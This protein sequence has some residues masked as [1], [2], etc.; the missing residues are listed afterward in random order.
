MLK[1]ETLHLGIPSLDSLAI[2]QHLLMAVRR[3]GK[4]RAVVSQELCAHDP[5]ALGL[6]RGTGWPHWQ[7]G[8][9]IALERA[10]DQISSLHT[11]E[12]IFFLWSE[13]V[14]FVLAVNGNC[15][16]LGFPDDNRCSLCGSVNVQRDF[17]I[18]LTCNVSQSAIAGVL[19][20]YTTVWQGR[21]HEN[22]KASLRTHRTLKMGM[23]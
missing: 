21:F 5:R 6:S 20:E 4:R 18:F 23:T 8:N 7:M 17:I 2:D 14:S 15:R 12:I 3:A 1:A 16:I 9:V 19:F 22:N 11:G 13:A 10:F